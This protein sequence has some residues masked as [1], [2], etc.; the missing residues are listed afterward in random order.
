MKRRALLLSGG[1]SH[2]LNYPRYAN[3]VAAYYRLLTSF[4]NYAESDVY[5]CVGPGGAYPLAAGGGLR[6]V[7]AAKRTPVFDVLAN[8]AVELGEDDLLFVM[9]TD[10]GDA[11][12]GISLWGKGAFLAPEAL[13]T[14]LRRSS[15]I[16][17]LVL[18]QCYAGAFGALDIGRAVVCCACGRD[19]VSFPSPSPARGVEPAHNEF[20]YQLAG[21]LGGRYPDDLPLKDPN[22][23]RPPDILIGDAFRYARANDCWYAGLRNYT[24]LPQIFDPYGLADRTTLRGPWLSSAP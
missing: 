16:K 12:E 15:A 13:A 17:I 21:A 23:P 1:V 5:V 7:H 8:V 14:A 24:E 18:G 22:L 10:H 2:N 3:D 20:L 11:E 4:Y 9:V 6:Q 19:A